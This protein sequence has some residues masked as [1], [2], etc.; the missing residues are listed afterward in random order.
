MHV[1][2]DNTAVARRPVVKIHWRLPRQGC[3]LTGAGR[4]EEVTARYDEALR[5]D[6]RARAI[7]RTGWTRRA[8]G[9][10]GGDLR[11][12]DVR[13]APSVVPM[14]TSWLSPE[15]A[16]DFGHRFGRT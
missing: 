15:S 16:T 6:T 1:P 8:E 5:G 4:F 3:T 12:V 9:G 7:P 11:K 10:Q 14:T 2:S 13:D